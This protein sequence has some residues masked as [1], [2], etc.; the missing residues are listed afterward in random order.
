MAHTSAW[1]TLDGGS[2]LLRQQRDRSQLL[3]RAAT[4]VLAASFGLSNQLVMS[5]HEIYT[6]YR[7]VDNRLQR[8]ELLTNQLSVMNRR[9]NTRDELLD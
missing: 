4:D 1:Y 2:W 9:L 5:I 3:R 7:I 8:N 6:R